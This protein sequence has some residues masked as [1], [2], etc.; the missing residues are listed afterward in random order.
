MFGPSG[1]VKAKA[2]AMADAAKIAAEKALGIRSPS[3][4][5]Y[6]IGGFTG[7][8][9]INALTDSAKRVYNAGSAMGDSATKGMNSAI[10]KISDIINSD[11]DS[12]PVIRPVLDLSDVETGAGSIGGMFNNMRVRANL[13]AIS[14]GVNSR[15]Q[16]GVNDDVIS[17]INNL[18]NDL[19]NLGGNTYN[20]NGITYD[21]GSNITNA[22]KELIRAAKVER[23]V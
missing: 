1:K 7:E 11:I 4:V 16:N 23:R 13:N 5:F 21:D 22:V 14:Q 20:V 12:Q 3:R 6:K 19:S 2:K 10:S 8:G 17:A 18:R 9:F 15:L